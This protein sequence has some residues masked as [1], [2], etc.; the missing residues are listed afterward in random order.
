MPNQEVLDQPIDPRVRHVMEALGRLDARIDAAN[1]HRDRL[2]LKLDTLLAKADQSAADVRVY[3]A[4]D[5]AEHKQIEIKLANVAERLTGAVQTLVVAIGDDDKGILKR[6]RVL[7][8]F[9]AKQKYTLKGAM[10]TASVIG[11]AIGAAVTAAGLYL[12]RGR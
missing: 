9:Q 5:A 1:D 3:V 10:A 7:E 11:S 4:N 6:L 12:G 8:D 2:E